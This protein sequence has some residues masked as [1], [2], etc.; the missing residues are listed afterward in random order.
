MSRSSVFAP[1]CLGL[2]VL[3]GCAVRTATLRERIPGSG[4]AVRDAAR[5]AGRNLGYD[6]QTG[7]LRAFIDVGG[8]GATRLE[9][10]DA[11]AF[12]R[13]TDSGFLGDR[14]RA[15]GALKVRD[16]RDSAELEL[17]FGVGGGG[18]APARARLFAEAVRQDLELEAG[19][20]KPADNPRK[21]TAGFLGRTLVT[22][23]WGTH[24]LLDGNPLAVGGTRTAVYVLPLIGEAGG[25]GCVA[26][27]ALAGSSEERL[28]LLGQGIA[29]LVLYRGLSLFGLQDLADYNR[30]A[31][32]PYD[33]LRVPF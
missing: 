29:L 6:V 30:A 22:P 16:G 20:R 8:L 23:L 26:A 5:R 24:Y 33:L 18:D 2:V 17:M 1:L 10:D 32:S 9:M 11:D 27:S 4:L 19:R 25:W 31:A 15:M 12:L 13:S 7:T 14:T 28:K 21:S 3:S